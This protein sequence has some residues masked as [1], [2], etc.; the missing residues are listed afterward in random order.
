MKEWGAAGLKI[1]FMDSDSQERFRWYDDILRDTA[2]HRLLVNFHGATLPKGVQRT[3][4]HVMTLEA[5]Y[6]AEQGTVPAAGLTA[7]PYTRNAVGSTDYTPMGFQFG[8]RTVS[9]AAELALSVVLESGFQNFAGS[10]AAYRERPELARF[11]EQ[12]TALIRHEIAELQ[13]HSPFKQSNN[14]G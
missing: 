7:L 2:R 1:D 14:G 6:G 5:V 3:W 9:D 4:P 10:V 12:E 13:A 8:T 11:L